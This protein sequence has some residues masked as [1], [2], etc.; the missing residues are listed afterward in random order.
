MRVATSCSRWLVDQLR[1]N[2]SL[3]RLGARTPLPLLIPSL[4]LVALLS[5]AQ[6]PYYCMLCAAATLLLLTL[7]FIL[8][9]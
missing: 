8:L 3:L 9:L 4:L 1:G 5:A 7:D 6:S 2:S